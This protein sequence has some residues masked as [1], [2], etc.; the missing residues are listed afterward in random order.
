MGMLG[1]ELYKEWDDLLYGYEIEECMVKKSERLKEL[2][3]ITGLTYVE[4]ADELGENERTLK[5]IHKLRYL[6]KEFKRLL[7]EKRLKV[8]M[9]YE[10]SNLEYGHQEMIYE[11]FKERLLRWNL[12]EFSKVIQHMEYIEKKDSNIQ[13]NVSEDK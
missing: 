10:L 11:L 5:R 9:A 13:S 1:N 6:H 2:K 4:L 12:K 8:S 3:E 7:I